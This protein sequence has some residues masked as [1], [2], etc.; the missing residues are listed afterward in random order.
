MPT[1]PGH[2]LAD[3]ECA[4]AHVVILDGRFAT[5]YRVWRHYDRKHNY[6]D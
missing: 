4:A 1:I 6:I 3:R 5:N 2:L